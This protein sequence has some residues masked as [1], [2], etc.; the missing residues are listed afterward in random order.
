MSEIPY[1]LLVRWSDQG[2]LQGAHYKWRDV[3]LSN[4]VAV[5]ASHI[6]T[7]AVELGDEL[8]GLLNEVCQQALEENE[9][10]RLQAEQLAK[11]NADLIAK[12]AEAESVQARTIAAL[13]LGE[14]ARVKAALS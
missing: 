12:L 3:V 7:R 10:L 9:A 5:A 1:E 4:G 2:A 11:D 14:L 13:T 8:S 6:N